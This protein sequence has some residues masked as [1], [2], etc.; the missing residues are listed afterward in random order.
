MTTTA[1][2][3]KRP[4]GWQNQPLEDRPPKLG[5]YA[6]AEWLAAEGRWDIRLT[7]EGRRFVANWTAERGSGVGLL[8]RAYGG[9]Y[10]TAVS[11]GLSDEELESLC[12]E[13]TVQATRVYDPSVGGFST[14][15]GYWIVN[16]VKGQIRRQG[17]VRFHERSYEVEGDESGRPRHV[18]DMIDRDP[19]RLEP[20]TAADRLDRRTLRAA[21]AD[22][23]RY[24]SP[25]DREIATLCYG[26]GGT[27]PQSNAEI[28]RRFGMTRERVRQVLARINEKLARLLSHLGPDADTPEKVS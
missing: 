13:A 22:A 2:R 26:L 11:L 17:R 12:F 21:V 16:M 20:V 28:G 14:I 1:D 9:T 10:S 6:T 25:R 5:P 19:A 24:L 18:L 27:D 7:A 4:R 3:P 8:R 15:L 23:L